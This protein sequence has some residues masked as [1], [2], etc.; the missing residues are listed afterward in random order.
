MFVANAGGWIFRLLFVLQKKRVGLVFAYS[1]IPVI[2]F[3]EIQSTHILLY[4]VFECFV[5]LVGNVLFGCLHQEHHLLMISLLFIPQSQYLQTQCL[6]IT[7]RTERKKGNQVLS[8]R[9]RMIVDMPLTQFLPSNVVVIE[10]LIPQTRPDQ[11][12]FQAIKYETRMFQVVVSSRSYFIIYL[13]L[14]LLLLLL[15]PLVP[16]RL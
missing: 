11:T 9:Q 8:E 5:G 6:S 7:E 14:V 12:K 4:F 10:V 13:L 3:P 1:L 16:P 15:P 2:A